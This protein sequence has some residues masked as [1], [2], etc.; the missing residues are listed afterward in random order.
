MTGKVER[1]SVTVEKNTSSKRKEALEVLR[2][3]IDKANE[4][5]SNQDYTLSDIAKLYL[6]Y[7]TH[8]IK[9]SSCNTLRSAINTLL[10]VVNGDVLINKLTAA[11]VINTLTKSYKSPTTINN[12]ITLIKKI[13]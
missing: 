4:Y 9:A 5:R 11:Y 3:K 13:N 2:S 10:Q 7:Q 8:H 12:K 1:V 6:K